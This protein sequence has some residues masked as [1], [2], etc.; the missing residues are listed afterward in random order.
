MAIN[1][2]LD[3]HNIKYEKKKQKRVLVCLEWEI[4]MFSSGLMKAMPSK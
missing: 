4:S 1:E 3:K 2:L